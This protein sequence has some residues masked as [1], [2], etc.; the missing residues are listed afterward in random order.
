[1]REFLLAGVALILCA[2]GCGKDYKVIADRNVEKLVSGQQK[3]R[4]AIAFFE[5]GGRFF[6]FDQTSDI[7]RKVVLPLLGRIREIAVTEQLVLLDSNDEN[8]AFALV[9]KLPHDAATVDRIA[10]AVEEADATFAGLILQQWGRDWLVM[11][12][13]DQAT[14]EFLKKNNPDID[15]QR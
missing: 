7:D 6:D 2:A 3:K 10:Q 13:V 14:Y 4:E 1:M 12:L 15:K 5:K 8:R 11:D 9:V